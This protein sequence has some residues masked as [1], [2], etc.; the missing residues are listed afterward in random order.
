MPVLHFIMIRAT[1]TKDKKEQTSYKLVVQII[2]VF[3]TWKNKTFNGY[4]YHTENSLPV[5]TKCPD[6]PK[7]EHGKYQ[8]GV[9]STF[10]AYGKYND[11]VGIINPTGG[12]IILNL[13][14]L[15]CN[16]RNKCDLQLQE[17]RLHSDV[18][19]GW[20]WQW[21]SLEKVSW[22]HVNQHNN[23]FFTFLSLLIVIVIT[24]LILELDARATSSLSTA[25]RTQRG[26]PKLNLSADNVKEMIV[27][28][29]GTLSDIV[30]GTS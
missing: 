24:I 3:D 11:T 14:D 16:S 13:Q 20:G 8:L 2:L 27:K 9:P 23:I 18:Q 6:P 30:T 4:N 29:A 19:R 22:K 5:P 10:Y 28:E 26:F 12:M 1:R 7:L 15:K 17:R 21:G 25:T